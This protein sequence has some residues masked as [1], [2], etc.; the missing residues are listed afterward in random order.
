M[1][2][3]GV[4]ALE[5]TPKDSS[6]APKKGGAKKSVKR[7]AKEVVSASENESEPETP[8]VTEKAEKAVK[9]TTPKSKVIK[10]D[11]EEIVVADPEAVASK[12]K[13]TSSKKKVAAD[14]DADETA[15]AS[16]SESDKKKRQK[17]AKAA[18]AAVDKKIKHKAKKAKK[19]ESSDSG[20]DSSS[21]GS[22]DS[23]SESD[24]KKRRKKAKKAKKAKKEAK[25]EAKK[26]VE[27]ESDS[28]DSDSDV[29]TKKKK[30][31][32]GKKV[33][34]TKKIILD[35]GATYGKYLKRMVALPKEDFA[36]LEGA[37]ISDFALLAKMKKAGEEIHLA[38]EHHAPILLS[39]LKDHG[40]NI[41][42]LTDENQS[43]VL[44]KDDEGEETK[45]K[46]YTVDL[47]NGDKRVEEGG[48]ARVIYIGTDLSIQGKKAGKFSLIKDDIVK[49]KVPEGQDLEAF[50]QQIRQS[51][52]AKAVKSPDAVPAAAAAAAAS[53]ATDAE[54]I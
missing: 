3:S 27:S 7:K 13:K 53:T 2:C 46:K 4:S 1:S 24:K 50:K 26:K 35:H 12:K 39:V 47:P 48:T 20:S 41:L 18:S 11:D 19:A 6:S 43:S 29:D 51:A 54:M 44:V 17:K 25:K 23:E 32:K 9:K 49:V 22:S 8:E 31:K 30:S 14:V 38:P 52:H 21:S 40:I 45:V 33:K 28:S 16:E 15:D 36:E 34:R 37:Y 10:A 42:G 5:F